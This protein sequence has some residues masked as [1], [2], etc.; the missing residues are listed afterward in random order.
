MQCKRML[1][2]LRDEMLDSNIFSLIDFYNL[3]VYLQYNI[4]PTRQ[5]TSHQ[6]HMELCYRGTKGKA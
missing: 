3:C 4:Q 6:E 2:Q 5:T 1:C